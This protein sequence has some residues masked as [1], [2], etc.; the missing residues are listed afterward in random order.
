MF[1][2]RG[3]VAASVA[4]GIYIYIYLRMFFL[5]GLVAASVACGI[6]IY[7][8]LR[9]FFLRGLVA[10]S[11]ACGIYIYEGSKAKRNNLTRNQLIRVFHWLESSYSTVTVAVDRCMFMVKL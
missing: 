7:I 1:F 11:V 4:C 6:Y 10:A 2:L 8:Y 9:M 5:R 3:L